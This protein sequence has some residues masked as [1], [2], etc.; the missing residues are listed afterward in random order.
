MA[1][2]SIYNVP[3]FRA[4]V[5]HAKND[6]VFVA[7]EFTNSSTDTPKNVKYYYALKDLAANTSVTD[8]TSWGGITKRTGN[9]N[10][11]GSDTMPEFLWVP[12]YNISVNSSP[13]SNKIVF[14][15]GYEQRFQDGIYNNLIKLD[16]SFEMRGDLESRA[17]LHFLKARKG[18]ESFLVKNLPPIYADGN[19]K[20]R[21]YCP[22]FSSRF[23]F[24]G[25]HS[26]KATFIETNN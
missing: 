13:K 6:I 10:I 1:N 25:N 19:Y 2:N 12:S 7:E 4:S 26:I 9:A 11:D 3:P 15:N 17:I 22:S 23:T 14:G 5:T 24:H 21:F 8:T 20:K 18:V 16:V